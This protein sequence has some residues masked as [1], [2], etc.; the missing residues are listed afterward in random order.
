MLK[1]GYLWIVVQCLVAL[2]ITLHFSMGAVTQWFSINIKNTLTG[3]NQYFNLGF[4]HL[5]Y[6]EIEVNLNP[7]WTS[8]TILRRTLLIAFF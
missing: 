6:T 3:R 5:L 8:E 4:T 1:I 7:K 2:Y